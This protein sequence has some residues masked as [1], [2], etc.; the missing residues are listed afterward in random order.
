MQYIWINLINP[1]KYAIPSTIE[2]IKKVGFLSPCLTI[3]GERCYFI[4]N[5]DDLHTM[6]EIIYGNDYVHNKVDINTVYKS[7][8]KELEDHF[9]VNK[10]DFEESLNSIILRITDNVK[11]WEVFYSLEGLELIDIDQIKFGNTII[12]KFTDEVSETILEGMKPD[13]GRESF[14]A[15]VNKFISKNLLNKICI[16]CTVEADYN[17][18]V[19]IASSL[20][21]QSINILRFL[22]CVITYERI[23]ENLIKINISPEAYTAGD[24]KL[25]V[26]STT[27]FPTLSTGRG[28][29]HLELF[30]VTSSM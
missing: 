11:N 10:A 26:D 24:A 25:A 27:G 13:Q 14:K 6:A 22:T 1:K 20:A 18:A 21:Q 3:N 19:K 2:E 12:F 30:P 4:D 16:K 5:K 23:A 15:P 17:K 9:C 8:F 29:Q 7:I 28:R